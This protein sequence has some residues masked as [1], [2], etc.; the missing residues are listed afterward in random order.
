MVRIRVL[1]TIEA[2]VEGRRVDLGGPRQRAVL[3]M[4]LSTR[5]EVVPVDRLIEDL[6]RGQPPRSATASLQ[7]YVS[8]LRRLL[9]P[10]RL[11]RA[12]ARLLVSAPPGYAVRLDD[13]AVDAWRFDGLVQRAR[14]LGRS[15][16]VPARA[17]LDE[18]VGLWRG[19][20][21]AE[22]ADEPWAAAEAARLEQSRLVARESLVEATLWTGAAADAVP[23]AEVLT[24]Q[25]PL[26]EEGWRLLTLALWGSG[27]QAD[28][29]AALRRS[30]R[31]LADELGLDPGPALVELEHAILTQQIEVLRASVGRD[32]DASAVAVS[33]PAASPSTPDATGPGEVFVGRQAELAALQA[34]ASAVR[35]RGS[36]VVMVTG[37]AGVGKSSLLARF[38]QALESDGWLVAVGRCPDAEGAPPAWAWVESLRSLA[39]R[40]PPG[41]LAG[42]LAPL[43][44]DDLHAT[45]EID[46]STGRFRLHR[47]VCA[48]LRAAA[49]SRPLAMV[50]DDLHGA[51]AETLALLDS[52]AEQLTGR[53]CCLSSH[54]APPT[55]VSGCRRRSRALLADR[56][57]A[58]RWAACHHRTWTYWSARSTMHRWTRRR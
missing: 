27:R 5:R 56:P 16:P 51:D 30:R 21:Y 19:P 52:A 6:W 46:A 45:G 17:L 42:P 54:S 41:E 55:P 8:N 49:R 33:T 47:A 3:A 25:Q 39:E 58:C 7:V 13:E 12:P 26:R 29:L 20:A 44:Q 18:A 57:G 22:V 28:A 53:R 15:D 9:E 24:R 32:E 10:D 31:V 34:A 36:H 14:Q 11:P 43:L 38:Q 48:W 4:L 2:E 37:E 1:G 40:A 50:L 35:G 23:A